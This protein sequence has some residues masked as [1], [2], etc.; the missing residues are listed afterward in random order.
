MA[1]RGREKLEASLAACDDLA[2]AQVAKGL[3]EMDPKILAKAIVTADSLGVAESM[4]PIF[5]RLLSKLAQRGLLSASADGYQ[6][7]DKFETLAN[8][9]DQELRSFLSENSGHLTEALLCAA[10]CSELGPVLRGE[11]DAVQILFAGAGADL[12]D[13]FYGD[14]LFTSQWLE[15]SPRPF[16]SWPVI[17]PKGADC[18]SS[19][20]EPAQAV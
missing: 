12:L 9:A 10:T 8:S 19:R 1:S 17:C 5:D 13:H 16:R 6:A 15:Q 14:G 3:C 7:T 11:K 4:R 18:A 20:W 2:A